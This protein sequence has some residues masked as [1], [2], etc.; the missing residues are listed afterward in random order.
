MV[1]GVA[2][3]AMAEFLAVRRRRR[4]GGGVAKAANMAVAAVMAV[5]SV[6]SRIHYDQGSG[7]SEPA[8]IASNQSKSPK[9]EVDVT[10]NEQLLAHCRK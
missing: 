1:V 3:W 4:G 5:R 2:K 10:E 6:L 8:L 7:F 9:S